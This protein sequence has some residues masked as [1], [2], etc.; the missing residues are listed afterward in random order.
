MSFFLLFSLPLPL[1]FTC[2]V[3]LPRVLVRGCFALSDAYLTLNVSGPP[4]LLHPRVGWV[5]AYVFDYL[6]S[7]Q[8]IP[9]VFAHYNA[10]PGSYLTSQDVHTFTS[11]FDLGFRW[12]VISSYFNALATLE[13][14]AVPDIP[15]QPPSA[16]RQ[17]APFLVVMAPTRLT[18]I[19]QYL[20]ALKVVGLTPG[21]MLERFSGATGHSQSTVSAIVISASSTYVRFA[22]NSK[23]LKWPFLTG[24]RA[25]CKLAFLVGIPFHSP[26][27]TDAVD[28]LLNDDLEGGGL[29]KADELHTQVYRTTDGSDL[30]SSASSITRSTTERIFTLPPHW[31]NAIDFPE[32]ATRAVDF[33]PGK[34]MELVL[35]SLTL[36][37]RG[38]RIIIPGGKSKGDELSNLNNVKYENRWSKRRTLC[39]VKTSGRTIHIDAPFSRLLGKPPI[40]VADMTRHLQPSR[41][42]SR[43]QNSAALRSKVAEIQAQILAGVGITMN[44]LHTNPRQHTF[45]LPL[46]QEMC[47]EG[48]PIEGFCVAADIP[49]A[50]KAAETVEG[51]T[52]TGVDRVSFK[53]GSVD[54]IRQVISIA[55][56]VPYFPIILQWMGGRAGG[57]HSC[58]DVHRPILS[59]YSSIRQVHNTTLIGGSSNHWSYLIGDWSVEYGVRSMLFDDFPFASRVTIAMEARTSVKDLIVAAP[60]VADA[61][62][63]APMTKRLTAAHG[64]KLWK[65]FDNTIFAMPKERRAAWL[66]ER[67]VEIIYDKFNR[68]FQKPWFGWKKDG[69]AVEHPGD[70]TCEETVLRTVCLMNLTGDWLRHIEERFAYANGGGQIPSILQSFTSL[71]QPHAF[72][73]DKVYF[74]MIAQRRSRKP[75][76][77]IPTLDAP[78]EVWLKKGPVAVVHPKVKDE[79]IKDMPGNITKDLI[80][81]LPDQYHD[82]DA[83]TVPTI[84][85]LVPPPTLPAIPVKSIKAKGSLVFHL[86]SA[87]FRFTE[88]QTD[89]YWRLWFGDNETILPVGVRETFCGP[90][91]KDV[92]TFYDVVAI[93]P[94]STDGDLLNLVHLSNGFRMS[95]GASPLHVGD[96]VTN[97]AKVAFVINTDAGKAVKATGYIVHE[98][99]PVTEATSSFLHHG[100]FTDYENTFEIVQEPD[101]AEQMLLSL[102]RVSGDVYGRDKVKRPV[103]TGCVGFEQEGCHGNPVVAHVQRHGTAEGTATYLPNDGYTM[104]GSTTTTFTT[105]LSNQRCTNIPKDFNPIRVN[106]YFSNFASLPGTITHGMRF[107]P[108]IR[109]FLGRSCTLRQRDRQSGDL[110]RWRREG[111][112]GFRRGCP[113]P[114]AYVLTGHGSWEPGTG[115]ELYN[116]S[117]TARAVWD[118]AD[119][120][121]LAVYGSSVIEIVKGNSKQMIIRFGCVEDQAIHTRYMEMA[122]GTMDYDGVVHTFPLLAISTSGLRDTIHPSGPLSATQFTQVALVVAEEAVFE[123]FLVPFPSLHPSALFSIVTSP[124]GVLSSVT[125][126]TTPIMPCAVNTSGISPSFNDSTLREAVDD[127]SRRTAFWRL[128]ISTSSRSTSLNHAGSRRQLVE[129]ILK[130]E[131][132]HKISEQ[133]L[134]P[135]SSERKNEKKQS[136]IGAKDAVNVWL[137]AKYTNETARLECLGSPHWWVR[138]NYAVL[139]LVG[140]RPIDINN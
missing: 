85:Y 55:V 100:R 132:S 11:A 7:F 9:R 133:L 118:A 116:D 28:V 14:S 75:V 134:L 52:K 125:L 68:N 33:G 122:Y 37:R 86:L 45:Q 3:S 50:E 56:S 84:D 16:M 23:A 27:L 95:D 138:R 64:V 66:A 62:R 98:R 110:Q 127:I 78:S 39:S 22:S 111:S 77:F 103:K 1:F 112:R 117:P 137:N 96:V 80:K 67:R 76:P 102:D 83:S 17:S 44:S 6:Q 70:M 40:T 126:Q 48:L 139:F 129:D 53:L 5:E 51:L 74:L 82:C 87:P 140:H 135:S 115:M 94:Q 123:D 97:E 104:T 29:W 25:Q 81:K 2:G 69:T 38:V 35:L 128:S 18:Q 105:P 120:H 109:Y 36:N 4:P 41:G 49:T 21:E 63:E 30:R 121:L 88:S 26:Y 10:F 47:R 60:G 46:W 136:G 93:S 58:E 13:P 99:K 119:V 131:F 54:G 61:H 42:V 92:K 31:T 114:T 59:T 65:E 91:A 57:H 113:A 106:P 19:T 130:E 15:R 34:P 71:D 32:T 20:V 108:L 12:T 24:S 72:A 89:F 79:P 124:H 43:S 90:T 107:H 73:E 101:H 8:E